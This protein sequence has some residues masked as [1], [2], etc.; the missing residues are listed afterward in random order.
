M[1][2]FVFLLPVT[3]FLFFLIIKLLFPES[4]ALW[5][6]EDAFVE[7]GQFL[8]YFL[9]SILSVFAAIKF[10]RNKLTLHGVLYGIL[11]L[12]L[13]FICM[14]EISW[15]QR[16]FNIATPDI[17]SKH[18]RQY[19]MNIHNMDIIGKALLN[20]IYI[21]I[22]AY[23]AFAWIFVLSFMSGIKK[24]CEHIVNFVVPDWYISPYFIFI[25]LIYVLLDFMAPTAGSFLVWKDQ[26]VPE[27]LLS[28]GFLSFVIDSNIKLKTCLTN[29]DSAGDLR[30]K[31]R[32][33][34]I[35]SA[36]QLFITLVPSVSVLAVVVLVNVF[37]QVSVADMTRDVS[38]IANIHPL[39]GILS[40]L[41]ILLWCVTASICF[42]T[43][44]M[45]R[46]I[47]SKDKFRFLLFSALLSAYCMIDD[48]FQVH[49]Y[50]VPHYLGLNEKVAILAL[51]I[52]TIV[53][54]LVFMR[55]I[56]QTNFGLLLLALGF[57]ASSIVVDTIFTSLLSNVI[58]SD[59][60][61]L[62]EDGFKWLG[63]AAWCSY[64]VHTCYQMLV[65]ARGASYSAVVPDTRASES[66][67]LNQEKSD[68]ES[69]ESQVT[70]K[71]IWDTYR[72]YMIGIPIVILVAGI[73][74]TI[75]VTLN[76]KNIGKQATDVGS[77]KI[78]T[79]ATGDISSADNMFDIAFS[80]CSS[81]KCPDPLKAIKYL[82]EAI[83]LNPDFSAA[84]GMRGNIYRRLGQYQLAINDYHEV[85]RRNPDDIR[86]YC[87]RANAYLMQGNKT[88]SC[89]DAQKACTLGNC[90][91]FD[92]FK[93]K[94][95]C[96]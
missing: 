42:F 14:E 15:G 59:L 87:N 45:I 9:S 29:P 50:L 31:G 81:K 38:H 39:L 73:I 84:Y 71:N 27:L 91:I 11:A 57:L 1:K 7:N 47:K 52:A 19:E 3:L 23:G 16:I 65:G 75:A 17:F 96:H 90:S 49:E 70:L 56:L 83:K 78:A 13:F 32:A 62:L 37:Y 74:V 12:G 63:I 28:L 61:H 25:F 77:P 58:G 79:P 80:L 10:T 54:L 66:N 5:V 8:F 60:N 72:A 33:M 88:L 44:M 92:D 55:V 40:N 46:R 86:A 93:R 6:E 24:K 2:I 48:F 22:G 35:I 68:T 18:N 67:I 20:K 76:M 69:S 89:S 85:I 26:E 34:K 36:R 41:G 51:G 64:F 21:L 43:T 94:G 82:N 53:Y 30:K 95:L 4:Y